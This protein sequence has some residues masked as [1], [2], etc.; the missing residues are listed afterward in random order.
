MDLP[1]FSYTDTLLEVCS[2]QSG[3]DSH[4][5]G[6]F[7]VNTV[8][9]NQSTRLQETESEKGQILFLTRFIAHLNKRCSATETE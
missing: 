3:T 8:S 1:K 2:S 4:N 9:I 6:T 5:E 7:H